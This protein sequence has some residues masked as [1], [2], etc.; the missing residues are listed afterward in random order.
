MNALVAYVQYE[1]HIL[2][3]FLPLAWGEE[4]WEFYGAADGKGGRRF[5]N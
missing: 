1:S 3:K 5:L 4:L 2:T